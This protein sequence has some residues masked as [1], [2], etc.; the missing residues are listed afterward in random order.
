MGYPDLNMHQKRIV[1]N[2][3]LYLTKLEDDVSRASNQPTK[4]LGSADVQ[5]LRNELIDKLNELLE[6]VDE[7]RFMSNDNIEHTLHN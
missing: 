1:D 5:K 6:A 2:F 7:N 4:L 3:V